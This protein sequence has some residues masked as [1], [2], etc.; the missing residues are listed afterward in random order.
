MQL[1]ENYLLLCMKKITVIIER[2]S[3]GIYTAVPQHK[4]DIGFIGCGKTVKEAMADLNQSLIEAKEFMPELPDFAFEIKYDTASFLQYFGSK[5]TLTG[6][7]DIT[8][9]NY[10]QLSRYLN[11]MGKPSTKTV[12]KIESGVRKFANELSS[13]VLV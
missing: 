11:G 6:L 1:V 13:V 3:D 12:C 5:L 4:Y 8:G 10:K 9:V 2:G 7:Q